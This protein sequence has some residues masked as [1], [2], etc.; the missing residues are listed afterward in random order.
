MELGTGD[1]PMGVQQRDA[2]GSRGRPSRSP[3]RKG[4]AGRERRALAIRD[5]V[6]PLV[7]SKGQKHQYGSAGLAGPC[8]LTTWEDGPFR[9]VLREPF[10]PLTRA[11]LS[12]D[13][14][15]TWAM[16]HRG[17]GPA[18]PP[19][20]FDVWRGEGMVLSVGWDPAGPVEVVALRPGAWE[21]EALALA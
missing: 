6:L 9:F 19:F 18:P 10:R 15:N 2:A 3:T 14:P 17:A 16:P 7:R 21:D 1:K 20:G 11:G 5:R 4:G 8:H 12:D 13:A